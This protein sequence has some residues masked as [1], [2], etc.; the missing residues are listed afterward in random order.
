VSLKWNHRHKMIMSD[1]DDQSKEAPI[2]NGGGRSLSGVTILELRIFHC[3]YIVSG[4][5]FC[6]DTVHRVSYCKTHYRLC[7]IKAKAPAS[8]QP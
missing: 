6:G 5:L 4:A 8:T 2:K 1:V 7:Y 3:R